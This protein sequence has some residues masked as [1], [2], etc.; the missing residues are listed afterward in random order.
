LI[1]PTALP[2]PNLHSTRSP[3][4][5]SFAIAASFLAVLAGWLQSTMIGAEM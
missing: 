1:L 2:R 4:F 3:R 5:S